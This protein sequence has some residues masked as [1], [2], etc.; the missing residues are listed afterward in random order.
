VDAIN[1]FFNTFPPVFQAIIL[2]IVA[3][4]VAWIAQRV[5]IWVMRRLRLDER[6]GSRAGRDA[7]GSSASSL[8]GKMVFLIVFLLFL[9]SVL[10]KLNMNSVASPITDMIRS[11]L[12]YLPNILAAALI[13]FIGHLI[14]KLIAELLES[15][16]QRLNIDRLQTRLGMPVTAQNSLAGI[17]AKAVYAL[18]MIF[19]VI[20]AL[21]ALA[22]HA[23]SDPAV[24]MLHRVLVYLPLLIAGIAIIWVGVF[25]GGLVGRLVTN[26]LSGLGADSWVAKVW[27]RS[28]VADGEHAAPGFSLSKVAGIV[29]RVVIVLFFVIEGLQVIHLDLLTRIGGAIIGYLPSALAAA[30]I[31][32]LAVLAGTW[33]ESLIVRRSP[34]HRSYAVAAKVT[35]LVVAVF[36]TLTQLHLSQQIVTIAFLATVGAVAVAFAIAF[37]V[38]GRA[39]AAGRLS[40]LERKLDEPTAPTEP[41][42]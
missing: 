29:V 25:L 6:I 10:N 12:R 38:G 31:M 42:Q 23:I 27:P 5:A 39:F 37:G 26:L 16:L 18:V 13:L 32:V 40:K 15:V 9:P 41:A 3:F 28:A 30:V 20:A 35:I 17:V 1:R 34:A 8:I 24:A 11:I 7:Q 19:V 21:Q 22:I 4:I 36:M 14:A 2:L 33:V